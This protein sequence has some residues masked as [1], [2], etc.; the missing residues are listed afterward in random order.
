M[1]Y[2]RTKA[3]LAEHLG[4]GPKPLDDAD[5]WTKKRYN[6]DF[7]RAGYL[8]RLERHLM[9]EAANEAAGMVAGKITERMK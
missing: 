6:L 5:T 9:T 4:L 3:A 8:L 1:T 2:A 7:G